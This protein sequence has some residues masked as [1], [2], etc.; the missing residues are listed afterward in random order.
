MIRTQIRDAKQRLVMRTQISD[1]KDR[2]VMRTQITEIRYTK[3][4]D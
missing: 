1:A 2:L 3:D 4:T